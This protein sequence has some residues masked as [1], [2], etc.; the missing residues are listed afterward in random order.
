MD[1]MIVART[2]RMSAAARRLFFSLNWMVVKAKLKIRLSR[3][4]NAIIRGISF[5]QVIKNTLPKDKRIKMYKKVQTG[6]KSHD[7]GDHDGFFSFE[8]QLYAFIYLKFI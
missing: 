7:G 4:G 5:C 2:K 6:P 8:Y 1:Q 3:N